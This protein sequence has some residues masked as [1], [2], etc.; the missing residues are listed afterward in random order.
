[1]IDRYVTAL[2][3]STPAWLDQLDALAKQVRG[4]GLDLLLIHAALEVVLTAVENRR[5]AAP[6]RSSTFLVRQRPSSPHLVRT[7]VSR[8][9][10]N[11]PPRAPP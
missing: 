11:V 6:L 3:R 1:M 9:P 4:E 8:I 5:N 10:G 7:L 2:P